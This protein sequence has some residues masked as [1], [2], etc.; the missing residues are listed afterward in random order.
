[1]AD[2]KRL[3]VGAAAAAF[4][5][6]G[7]GTAVVAQQGAENEAEERGERVEPSVGSPDHQE[8]ADAALRATEGGT[9]LEVEKGDDP[10][11]AYEV[12]VREAGGH[13]VEVLLD[14]D[15]GVVAR[16]TDE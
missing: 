6:L 2:R 12:E 11:A 16:E 10:G 4:L 13:V 5:T 15:F 1:M 7:A 14:G 3:L 9:V 8:A